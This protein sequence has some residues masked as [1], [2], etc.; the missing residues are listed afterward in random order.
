[1]KIFQITK[2]KADPHF[3]NSFVEDMMD[4]ADAAEMDEEEAFY[5][6]ALQKTPP[7]IT[8]LDKRV[9]QTPQWRNAVVKYGLVPVKEGQ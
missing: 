1:M 4:V 9:T 7:T 3:I 8:I 5:F 6:H 2:L